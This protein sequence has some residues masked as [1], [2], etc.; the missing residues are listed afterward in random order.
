MLPLVPFFSSFRRVL[1]MSLFSISLFAQHP[2]AVEENLKKAGDN[3]PELEKAIS[4]CQKTGDSE[5][6]K[7][8]YFL[9]AN[10]DIHSTSDYY[11]ENQAGEKIAYNELDYPDF[12]QASRAFDAIKEK[13]IGLHPKTVIYK[14]LETLKADLLIDNL[15]KSFAAWKNSPLKDI[16]FEEFCQYIL[17]YRI[18]VEPLQNWRAAYS[19]KFN[20]I[21]EKTQ[22]IGLEATLPYIADQTHS[23]FSNTWGKGGR[24]EPLPE[25]GSMQILM[26]KQGNCGD[27]ANLGVFTLRSAGIPATVSLIPYWATATGGHATNT[28][29]DSNKKTI[30]FDYASKNYKAK[31]IREPAK[32]L[33]YT[34]SKQPETLAS[35]ENTNNI[36]KG[37][38]QD[39]NYIDV[40]SEYWE[41]RD[42]KYNSLYP[43][44]NTP[45]TVY[46]ST[47][48][49]LK[50]QPF[51]W[52]KVNGNQTQFNKISKGTVILPQYYSNEKMIPAGAPMLVGDKENRVLIPNLTATHDVLINQLANYLIFKPKV[53]YKLFY[54]NDGWRLIDSKTAAENT[55]SLLFAKVPK[56]ALLL[57]LSSASKGLERPFVVNDK[58]ERTWF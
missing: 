18:G 20:W 39:Q 4:Y 46:I 33:R 30:A 3:R 1:L 11:W 31:L 19:A 47:F 25:L 53:T 38:L 45:K 57:L 13:N 12:E 9:I 7:A 10:M 23:W 6:L 22:E 5:K 36:P 55:Q 2:D 15:E 28:F 27:L 37:Y 34:Y 42:V 54:W 14:D 17:P 8:M 52:G 21:P 56:N 48:N 44:A 29:F 40:T 35:F 43:V 49:G 16:S 58:G 26:R 41:T 51:W 32:V 50:W 24:K